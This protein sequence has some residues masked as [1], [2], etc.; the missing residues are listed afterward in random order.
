MGRCNGVQLASYLMIVS[1]ACSSLPDR[2][3]LGQDG[4]YHDELVDEGSY[5]VYQHYGSAWRRVG[6]AWVVE[7]ADTTVWILRR[8]GTGGYPYKPPC[9]E[10][11][12]TWT[13][14]RR[15]PTEYATPEALAVGEEIEG[16]RYFA[17][18]AR[19]LPFRLE[20]DGSE[21]RASLPLGAESV[22]VQEASARLEAGC[23]VEDEGVFALERDGVAVGYLWVLGDREVFLLKDSAG[24]VDLDAEHT[25]AGAGSASVPALEQ[26]RLGEATQDWRDVLDARAEDPGAYEAW[27]CRCRARG[28]EIPLP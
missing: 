4:A 10:R 3:L 11:P 22:E 13:R 7:G 27:A 5:E 17:L 6:Y 18:E 1:G 8:V 21:A 2:D 14:F 12:E 20:P 26:R 15:L 28:E 19:S 23:A 24:V 16:T 9:E 25:G